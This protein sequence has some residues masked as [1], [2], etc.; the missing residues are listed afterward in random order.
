MRK[1][2]RPLSAN[3]GAPRGPGQQLRTAVVDPRGHAKAVQLY[4]VQPLRPGGGFS[5][6]WESCG[7]M[8][9]QG[10]GLGAT[11]AALTACEAERLT[12]GGMTRT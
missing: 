3:G 4:F 5:T 2:I 8:K 9:R 1:S 12:T 11:G 10:N 6:A 7:G